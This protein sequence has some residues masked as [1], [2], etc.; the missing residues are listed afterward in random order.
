LLAGISHRPSLTEVGAIGELCFL[1]F[2][3]GAAEAI[4]PLTVLAGREDTVPLIVRRGENLRMRAL[5]FLVG[6]LKANP[7]RLDRARYQPLLERCLASPGCEHTA[8]VA[9]IGFGWWPKSKE[10]FVPMLPKDYVLNEKALKT[11][12]Q[13]V[14]AALD[15]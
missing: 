3:M 15:R 7:D 13:L 10:E 9:L 5:R 12:L 4:E 2:R 6:L 14:D 11:D 8:L 1:A